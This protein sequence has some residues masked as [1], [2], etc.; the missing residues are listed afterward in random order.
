MKADLSATLKGSGSLNQD[1]LQASVHLLEEKLARQLGISLEELRQRIIKVK[2]GEIT[3][4]E[5]VEESK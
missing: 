3:V 5:A 2:N 1:P 4:D